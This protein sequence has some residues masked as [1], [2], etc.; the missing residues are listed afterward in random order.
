MPLSADDIRRGF[1]ALAEE[2]ASRGERAEMAV[3]GGAALVLLFNARQTTKD[4]DAYFIAPEA[5]RVRKAAAQVARDLELP[6]DWLNDS[7]K[8]YFVGVSNGESLYESPS[9]VIRAVSTPQLLAMKLAAWRDAI[10]R[11]DARL[12]LS[13][14]EG[15]ATEIWAMLKRFVPTNEVDKASYAF[16][17]LWE[18]I[19]GPSRSR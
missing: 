8:G 9:L 19:Y 11:A 17:D 5:S 1:T 2:L 16:D 6:E 3:A 13:R 12:L 10:D 15:S 14:M 4:V 18:S 7:A